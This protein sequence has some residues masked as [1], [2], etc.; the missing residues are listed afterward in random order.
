MITDSSEVFYL[1]K[2]KA[3]KTLF[4]AENPFIKLMDKVNLKIIF[5]Q[6][7]PMIETLDDEDVQ[8][9]GM[10]QRQR[11]LVISF[12]SQEQQDNFIGAQDYL[13]MGMLGSSTGNN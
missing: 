7:L 9:A 2:N 3:L 6:M 5:K 11:N 4:F 8:N 10:K 1:Q 12:S 13:N